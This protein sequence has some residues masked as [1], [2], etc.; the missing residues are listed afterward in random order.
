[1]SLEHTPDPERAESP[2]AA[3]REPEIDEEARA[4][5]AAS[6]RGLPWARGLLAGLLAWVFPGLG[7]A[8]SGRLGRGLL[9]AAVVLGLFAGGVA[10][11]G[12]VYRPVQGEPLSYLATLG[13]AGAGAPYVLARWVGVGTGDET[14]TLFEY[15]NAFTLVAGLLNMLIVFDAFDVAV[16]RRER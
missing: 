11:D 2:S 16:G 12:K 8:F 14:A 4:A 3:T 5:V 15:G 7:H 10:L 13:A 9:F 6:H 1:M